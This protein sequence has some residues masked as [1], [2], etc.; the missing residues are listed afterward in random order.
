MSDIQ[1]PRGFSL[2]PSFRGFLPDFPFLPA[3]FSPL[4]KMEQEN[5]IYII[6]LVFNLIIIQ[7]SLYFVLG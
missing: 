2:S 3:I 5:P 6:M 7:R 1:K 4:L